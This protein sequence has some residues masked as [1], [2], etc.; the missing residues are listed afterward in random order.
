[1]EQAYIL[2]KFT[3]LLFSIPSGSQQVLL[4]GDFNIYIKFY[5]QISRYLS[6]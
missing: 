5:L 4:N 6:F 3:V 2:G 1:M